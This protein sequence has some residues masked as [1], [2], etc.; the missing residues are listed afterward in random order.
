MDLLEHYHE[1]PPQ[2]EH[3]TLRKISLPTEGHINLYGARGS[4]KTAIILDYIDQSEKTPLYID[5]ED[6]NLILNTLETLPLQT[7]IDENNIEE[8]I[9]D[10][11]EEGMIDLFPRVKR[12]IILSRVPLGM[13]GFS[14]VQLFPL[15]YEEFLAFDSTANAGNAFNRFLKCGTLPAMAKQAKNTTLLMKQFFQQQFSPNEQA[16]ILILA[17]YHT[18]PMTTHQIYSFAKEHFKISKDFVYSAIKRFQSEGLL[19]FIDDVDRRSGKKMFVYDFAFAKY[20][21]VHQPFG[22]QFDSMVALALI[23][24]AISFRTLGIHG[25]ITYADELIVP[26]AFESEERF[27]VKAQKKFALYQQYGINKIT[28]VTVANSYNFRIGELHFEAIPFHEWSITHT[29]KES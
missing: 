14:G 13:P 28:I 24:H 21:T 19:Y 25:Y 8:L 26:A 1:N 20:L 22:V 29:E 2:N 17:R 10:H 6:P 12:L 15:D 16:L 27:W 11:Y 9:L 7:Y 23:K 4:G 18:Q 3:Y 5:L